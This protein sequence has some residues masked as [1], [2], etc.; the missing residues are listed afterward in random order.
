MYRLAT[1]RRRLVLPQCVPYADTVKYSS[2]T[3]AAVTWHARFSRKDGKRG[4]KSIRRKEGK[5]RSV[6]DA[7]EDVTRSEENSADKK[8]GSQK[9]EAYKRERGKEDEEGGRKGAPERIAE[10][11][12]RVSLASASSS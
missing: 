10:R 12:G 9:E 2:R 1:V 8:R 6:R 5:A 11:R 3:R 7:G 4:E